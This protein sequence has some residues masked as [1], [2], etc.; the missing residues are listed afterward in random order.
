M[1]IPMSVSVSCS[2]PS[3]RSSPD[4]SVAGTE[5]RTVCGPSV[6]AAPPNGSPVQPTTAGA[7]SRTSKPR[8]FRNTCRLPVPLWDAASAPSTVLALVDAERWS[9]YGRRNGPIPLAQ[10]SQRGPWRR[11]ATARRHRTW[12]VRHRGSLAFITVKNRELARHRS[13]GIGHRNE[14]AW[15]GAFPPLPTIAGQPAR[16]AL[17]G[18]AV[19]ASTSGR[20]VVGTARSH[21]LTGLQEPVLASRGRRPLPRSGE[22]ADAPT[23]VTTQ[24][25]VTKQH[26]VDP[27]DA[28]ARHR[29]P[30]GAAKR[31]VAV[32]TGG[33]HVPGARP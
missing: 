4:T 2:P 12:L 26:H 9:H 25:A 8:T 19:G 32:S 29:S 10:L 22:P 11:R 24:L 18:S 23:A 5:R 15:H 27:D 1:T 16:Q 7:P 30:R 33:T 6:T 28:P 3:S 17:V 21:A 31:V 20:E 14:P 13:T